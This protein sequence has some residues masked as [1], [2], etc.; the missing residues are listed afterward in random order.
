MT[1]LNFSASPTTRPRERILLTAHKLFYRDGIRATGID[2]LIAE[3]GVA[4]ATF[5]RHFPSKNDLIFAYL[6]FR[7]HVW[8]TWFKI[9]ITNHGGTPESLIPALTE[10]FNDPNFRGCAFLNS[11]GELGEELPKIV[12]QAR[13]HKAEMVSVIATI[14][15]S[16]LDRDQIAQSL[17][18]AIDGAIVRAQTE[19]QF[20]SALTSFE[21]I[22]KALMQ[23]PNKVGNSH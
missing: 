6:E 9:A 11:V 10:W 19:G 1:V 2:R 14:V 7:H 5:Y 8:I 13:T 4:K 20:D 16:H 23:S 15:P 21:Y 17:A 22:L 12:E 3:S 18:L